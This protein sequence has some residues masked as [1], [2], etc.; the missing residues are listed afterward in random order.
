MK[1]SKTIKEYK[2]EYEGYKIVIPVGSIVNNSTACGDDDNYRFW[3]DWRE[4]AEKLTGYKN[5]LLA[6]DLKHYGINIPAEYCE[7]YK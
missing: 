5:S 6:H 7:E 3:E 2:L 4:Q 1:Q